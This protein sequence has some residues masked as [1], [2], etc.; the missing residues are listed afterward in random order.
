[1][2]TQGALK[3]RVTLFVRRVNQRDILNTFEEQ[4]E[5]FI[6]ASARAGPGVELTVN[7]KLSFSKDSKEFGLMSK[8]VQGYVKGV[9]P[10]GEDRDRS[11]LFTL[12]CDSQSVRVDISNVYGIPEW[13]NYFLPETVEEVQQAPQK[14]DFVNLTPIQYKVG[15]MVVNNLE[16]AQVA[17]LTLKGVGH[18]VPILVGND[19]DGWKPLE[20]D[21]NYASVVVANTPPKGA[22]EKGAEDKGAEKSQQAEEAQEVVMEQ[23]APKQQNGSEEACTHPKIV[24]SVE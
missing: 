5:E 13:M 1:V 24:I 20:E 11:G 8:I 19:E 14:T 23:P 15:D 17:H 10:R 12:L 4:C 22:E 18:D 3:D 2:K 6:F 7:N 9:K 16:S 21:G